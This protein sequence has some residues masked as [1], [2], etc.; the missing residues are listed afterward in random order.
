MPNSLKVSVLTPAYNA[1]N[2]IAETIESVLNQTYKDFEYIICDDCST[3]KTWEIIQ[4][5]AL[6]DP[7]IIPIRNEKNLNYGGTYNK[8]IPLAKGEYIACQP[9][10]DISMPQRIERQLQFMEKNPD[11][12][13][14][15][16]YILLFDDNGEIGIRKYPRDDKSIRKVVFRYMPLSETVAMARKKNY[17]ELGFYDVKVLANDL[18]MVL[19]VGS[20]YELANIPEVLLRNRI[21]ATSVTYKKLKELEL[22]TLAVRKIYAHG[23]GYEMTSFDKMYNF[24]QRVSISLFPAAFRVWLFMKIRDSRISGMG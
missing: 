19:R 17:E 10:D 4:E 22:S 20:K 5:Y 13:I 8:M 18:E 12:G 2:F 9:A 16:A 24:L 1:E 23:R 7:R 11:V 6:R 21:H 14:C 15:G 3:D